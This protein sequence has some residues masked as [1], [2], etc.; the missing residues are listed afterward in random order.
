MNGAFSE[1]NEI[2]PV[3]I[4]V[5]AAYGFMALFGLVTY[6]FQ[7]VGI[8]KISASH[9]KPNGWLGFIP[10]GANYQLGA[11]SG[12]L[13]FGG[14]V[15]R[16]PGLWLVLLPL[17]SFGVFFVMY[18]GIFIVFIV[19]AV[20]AGVTGDSP[21]AMIVML[22]IGMFVAAFLMSFGLIVYNIICLMAYYKIFRAHYA[23]ARPV[24]YML[25]SAYVPLAAGI[26]LI[27]T[28]G[29]PIID[30]PEY[31]TRAPF[32]PPA[33]PPYPPHQAYPPHQPGQPYSPYQPH[34]PHQPY[35]PYPSYQPYS[36]YQPYQPYPLYQSYPQQP[37]YPQT[38]QPPGLQ[39]QDVTPPPP[40]DD[41]HDS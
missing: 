10:Y 9:G 3:F 23:G 11:V 4:M 21:V 17:I 25:L 6:V 26:L 2:L 7:A 32:G 24:F 41:T 5:I 31:M 22:T 1:L 14:R 34:H 19:G 27:K 18:I 33:Y 12:E 16:K 8:L 29:T 13:E 15:M 38:P 40:P 30:P 37:Q 36:T 28:S 20:N 39:N 35:Q